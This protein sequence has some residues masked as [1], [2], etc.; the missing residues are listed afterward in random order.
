MGETVSGQFLSDGA[1]GDK[2]RDL[3]SGEEDFWYSPSRSSPALFVASARIVGGDGKA[4]GLGKVDV[5]GIDH[6]GGVR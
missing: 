1:N 3:K 4:A 5:S 6:L 2:I